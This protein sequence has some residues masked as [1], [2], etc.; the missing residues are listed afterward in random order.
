MSSSTFRFNT[1]K[2]NI[3]RVKKAPY[4]V[5]IIWLAYSKW[6]T[7]L[8]KFVFYVGTLLCFVLVSKFH[9]F[10]VSRWR[11]SIIPQKFRWEWQK[12]RHSLD[13]SYHPLSSKKFKK[14]IPQ[15][16]GMHARWVVKRTYV[17]CKGGPFYSHKRKI[18]KKRDGKSFNNSFEYCWQFYMF[19]KYNKGGPTLKWPGYWTCIYI[20]IFIHRLYISM[21]NVWNCLS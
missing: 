14:P 9:L 11:I 5:S 7:P 12:R 13:P 16:Y 18:L 17:I 1:T 3:L 10:H 15:V 8:V 4:C 6:R 20:Y 21:R 19:P 2:E